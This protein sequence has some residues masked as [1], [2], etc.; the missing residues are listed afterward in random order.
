[1]PTIYTP[2]QETQKTIL[3]SCFQSVVNDAVNQFGIPSDVVVSVHQGIEV[4]KTDNRSNVSINAEPNLPATVSQ[5]RVIAAITEDYDEDHLTSSVVS[6]RDTVPIFLDQRLDVVVYP[7]YVRSQVSITFT[8]VCGSKTEVNRVRDDMRIRLSQGR[9]IL[10]HE[11]EYNILLPPEVEDFIADVYDLRN[12]L[13]P[14]TLREYFLENSSSRIR[15]ITDMANAANAKL[16][17]F[18]RQV[19]VVGTIDVSGEIPPVEQDNETNT[20]RLVIPYKVSM[21]I[22]RGMCMTY[23]PMVCN[24]LMPAKYLEFV[25]EQKIKEMQRAIPSGAGSTS[26][27]RLGHFEAQNQLSNRVDIALP[28]NIPLFD[29]FHL[30]Q[31]HGGYVITTTFLTDVDETD[32]CTL[33]DLRDLG[34][35]QFGE[36]FLNIIATEEY[37]WIVNPYMSPFYLGVHQVNA[38]HDNNILEITPELMVRSKVP[39]TLIRPTRICLSVCLDVTRLNDKT[40]SRLMANKTLYLIYLG[41]LIDALNNYKNE[42][43]KMAVATQTFY[44]H[45][46][47]ML[48]DAIVKEED[49]FVKDFFK[50]LVR[51]RQLTQVLIATMRGHYQRLYAKILKIVDIDDL[52]YNDVYTDNDPGSERYAMR[53]VMG[54]NAI[55]LTAQG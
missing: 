37:R 3:R 55:A 17:V 45:F 39:L 34:D 22:P 38:H 8:Y 26:I 36:S 27:N 20:Y 54:Y 9:N 12:R 41:E 7:V 14:Q 33:L 10:H 30:R 49:W 19:R 11:L 32:K 1:M 46:L 43:A 44:R 16:A 24:R 13:L 2:L 18:E 35:F 28:L 31:G 21:D 40:V 48:N 53:T 51:D 6:Q 5:R 47:L 52:R 42:Y 4:N 29:E 25:Q 23:P 15:P 50:I